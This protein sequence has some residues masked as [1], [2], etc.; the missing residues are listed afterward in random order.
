MIMIIATES[1][2][3]IK[4]YKCLVILSDKLIRTYTR[5]SY[6]HPHGR[7]SDVRILAL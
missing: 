3:L 1:Y 7:W 5:I 4:E 2:S 6:V